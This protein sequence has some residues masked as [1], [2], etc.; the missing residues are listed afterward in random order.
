MQGEREKRIADTGEQIAGREGG[1]KLNAETLRAQR[2]TREEFTQRTRRKRTEV[3]EKSN[4]RR[5]PKAAPTLKSK[6][7]GEKRKMFVIGLIV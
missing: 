7:S 5:R 1:R 2:R 6:E 4:P 3:A